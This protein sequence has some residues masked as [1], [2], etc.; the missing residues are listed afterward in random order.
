MTQNIYQDREFIKKYFLKQF[1]FFSAADRSPAIVHTQF[2][3]Y[4]LGMRTHGAQRNHAMAGNFR[5][6]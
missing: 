3:V 5:A 6:A 1:E 2:G 4:I